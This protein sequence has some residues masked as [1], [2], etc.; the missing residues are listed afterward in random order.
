MSDTDYTL[1]V[2]LQIAS[3]RWHL[4]EICNSDGTCEQ[5]VIDALNELR[6]NF[7]SVEVYE[8]A[9]TVNEFIESRTVI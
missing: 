6:D 4:S 5:G 7:A 8:L 2:H 1:P 3:L 9:G